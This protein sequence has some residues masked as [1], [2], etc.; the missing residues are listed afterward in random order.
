MATLSGLDVLRQVIGGQL[1]QPPMAHLM[2]IRLVEVANG[3]TVF[4]STPG[5]FHYNPLGTVHGGFGATLLDSAMGC[6][7]HSTLE[8]GDAYTTLELKINFLRPLTHA[9]GLVRGI[10][11]IVHA[12]R[13][14]AL[15]EGRIEDADGK[16][17]AFATST[18]LIR[19]KKG[20]D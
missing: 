12:G 7:V 20:R 9:T 17:Y 8:A 13:T 5:E 19:R 4:E 16:L 3:R 1:P 11:T 15:A 10:G 2:D 14:T 6:A 18:C